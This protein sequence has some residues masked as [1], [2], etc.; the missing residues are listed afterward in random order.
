MKA[1]IFVALVASVAARS[2]DLDTLRLAK[3]RTLLQREIGPTPPVEKTVVGDVI[4]R[5]L[6]VEQKQLLVDGQEQLLRGIY[7]VD[8]VLTFEEIYNTELF[9]EYLTIPLFR[10][11]IKYPV[12]QSTSTHLSNSSPA[13]TPFH[14]N[15]NNKLMDKMCMVNKTSFG[16]QS[17]DDL[18]VRNKNVLPYVYGQQQQDVISRRYEVP[19]FA[20][21]YYPT[22]QGV[23][24]K[25]LLEKLIKNLYVNQP[26]V[27]DVT[28][29]KTDVKVFPTTQKVV[30][31]PITGERKIV[32][33][34]KVVDVKV[35]EQI[36]PVEQVVAQQ[37]PIE[38]QLTREQL[39]REQLIREQLPVER[40]LTLCERQQFPVVDTVE[41][42]LIREQL[43]K[44][45]VK[46]KYLTPEV[47]QTIARDIPTIV[48]DIPTVTRD[49]PTYTRDITR[50]G[51]QTLFDIDTPVVGRREVYTPYTNRVVQGDR[52]NLINKL[53]NQL[54]NQEIPSIRE[55]TVFD[56]LPL[57]QV[58]G[59]IVA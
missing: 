21:Q 11:Y 24:Y 10:E 33:E 39:I 19:T 56:R 5:V 36:I 20:G 7:D 26:T 12:F 52:Y 37:L 3:E 47:Y 2:L 17:Y 58:L 16:R 31:E 48:R 34:P 22:T 51:R 30:I 23:N 27:G 1:F 38:R 43:L 18:I 29:V 4:D 42:Q 54:Y 41:R 57:Q 53:Y 8:R 50:E 13:S 15:T 32:E 49:I 45:L 59:N 55:N 25:F 6:P 46:E 9:R 14:T 35:N 40:Q 28:Q 44:D